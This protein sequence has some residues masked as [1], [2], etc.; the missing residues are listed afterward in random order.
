MTLSLSGIQAH[1]TADLLTGVRHPTH[2]DEVLRDRGVRGPT[3]V[4]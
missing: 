4:A 3:H 1:T 2:A